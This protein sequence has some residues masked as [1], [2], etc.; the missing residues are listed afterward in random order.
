M[1]HTHTCERRTFLKLS[2]RLAAL[3][4]TGLGLGATRTFFE[5]TLHAATAADYKALVCIYLFGGNDSNNMIVP[6]DTARYTA[7]QV[8]R[9]TLVLPSTRLLSPIPDA[10]NRPY[11]LPQSMAAVNAMFPG[12]NVAFILN[13]GPLNRPLTRAEYQAGGNAPQNLFSHSDQTLQAQAGISTSLRSGW[14]GRLLDAFQVSDNLAAVSVSSPALFLEGTNNRGNVV[15]PGANL[16]LSGMTA[17]NR[18]AVEAM[19]RLDGNNPMRQAANSAFLDGLLLG[20]RLANAE[21]LPALATPFPNTTLGSQLREVSRLIRLR[22]DRGPGRQVFFCSLGG[23]DTHA[24]QDGTHT[25]LLQQL[26]DAMAAFYSATVEI[27]LARNVTTFTQSEFGR[28]MQSNGTGTDHGWGGH[29][30]VAGGAVRGGIYGEMPTFE[31]SGPDDANTRGVWIP[32]IATAQFGATLG[33]WFGA[34]PGELEWAF[35]NLPA[36]PVYDVGFMQ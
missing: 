10:Q 3:G 27:G 7:Y 8:A 34:A 35:P 2:A 14:G 26:S 4:L 11:A 16:Q 31:L 23:F 20:D 22:A 33:R 32:R 6:V 13:M 17:A 1:A 18:A 30:I 15:P 5:R 36:F 19:L 24:S 28:T 25:G 12:G 9:G 21:Q 29:Q